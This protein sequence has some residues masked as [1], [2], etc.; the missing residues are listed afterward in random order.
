MSH[1]SIYLRL[2]GPAIATPDLS[3]TA[4]SSFATAIGKP[5]ESR[6][7]RA[8]VGG[9]VEEVS[10]LAERVIAPLLGMRSIAAVADGA[11]AIVVERAR[12]ARA[13]GAPVLVTVR[14]STS[15]RGDG[16]AAVRTLLDD[17]GILP[18]SGS[19][20]VSE[21]AVDPSTVLRA[22]RWIEAPRRTLAPWAG[23]HVGCGGVALAAAIASIAAGHASRVV[24]V[25][26]AP[27]RGYVFV[28]EKGIVP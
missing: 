27:D 28:L 4:E 1:A 12:D 5:I 23:D 22:S 8:A 19:I 10:K 3:A 11:S 15:Y 7:T 24:F 18:E 20:V 17:A 2:T 26:E 14:A 6:L 21:R 16:S 9:S 13:R 25:G